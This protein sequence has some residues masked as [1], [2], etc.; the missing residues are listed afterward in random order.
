MLLK[1][2]AG[3][4]LTTALIICLSIILPAYAQTADKSYWQQEVNYKIRVRLDDKSH[5]ISGF[6]SFE[7]KNNSPETLTELYIHLWPNA[8]KDNSTALAKQQLENG[9]VAFHYYEDSQRGY[10]DSLDFEVDG[11]PVKMFY[12]PEYND[13]CKILL[14]KPLA[15]G[16]K[17][18]VTTPFRVNI[19]GSFSRLGHT[20]QAY[21]VSQWYPKP[22]VFDKNGWHPMPYLDQ[23]EF[24]SEFG[25]YE[26]S[27]T[28]PA[29]YVVGAT[30]NLQNEEEQRFLDSL[31]D[32]T[33]L[34]KDFP[35]DNS[36]PESSESWKTLTYKQSKIHDFAWFADKRYHV[37]KGSVTLPRSQ[38]KVDTWVMFTNDQAKYWKDAIP[39]VNDAITSY[40]AWL[41]EYPYEQATALSGGLGAGGGMEYPNVTVISEVNSARSLER[42]IV[43]EVGHNWFY[44]ILGSNERDHGWMDEGLNTYYETRYM[45]TKYPEMPLLGRDYRVA[46]WFKLDQYP[47]GYTNDLIYLLMARLNEDQPV[48]T[49][50]EDFSM[51]NYAGIMYAKTGLLLRYLEQYLGPKDFEIAMNTYYQRWKF[52]HP[53]PED[54]KLVFEQVT[55]KNLDWFF[56]DMINTS[57]KIDFKLKSV[58]SEDNDYQVRVAGRGLVAPVFISSL[59]KNGEVLETFRSEPFRGTAVFYFD[60]Q[61]VHEIRVDPYNAIPEINRQNNRMRVKGLFR[62]T[63]PIQLQ[64]LMSLQDRDRSQ[65]YFTPVLGYNYTDRWMPGIAL[66][67]HFFPL[68]P[69]EFELIPLYSFET[70]RLNGRGRVAYNWYPARGFQRITLSTHYNAF[71][72]DRLRTGVYD[73]ADNYIGTDDYLFSFRKIAVQAEFEWKRATERSK[74][75]QYINLRQVWVQRSVEQDRV[76][77][78]ETEESAVNRIDAQYQVLSYQLKNT[79]RLNP[80]FAKIEAER[81]SQNPNGFLKLSA[82]FTYNWTYGKGRKNASLRTFVGTGFTNLGVKTYNA[83]LYSLDGT[84]DYKYDQT[85][86]KRNDLMQQQFY[87]MEGGFKSRILLPN[88]DRMLTLNAKVP[89]PLPLPLGLYGDIAFFK[90][91]AV[92]YEQDYV[93]DFGLYVPFI[94]DLIEVYF[95]V[96]ISTKTSVSQPKYADRIRFVLNITEM[97]PF[98]LIRRINLR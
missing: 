6:E 5:T 13:V 41:G 43:H 95:P 48:E 97:D 27:I 73:P 32:A 24:Y 28:L 92:Y 10:I 49:F 16:K 11:E 94:R 46:H 80:Y 23:G 22:A 54:L 25:S 79:R 76:L 98:R 86:L 71:S 2:R 88:V 20:G 72:E 38:R 52:R 19:P 30:G 83:G 91:S 77:L 63:E 21:Q 61:D 84:S 40:S 37:L 66:Y 59:D 81:M 39:Y 9:S 75:R 56:G 7:Y 78:D 1:R 70:D 57:G 47:A 58:K 29:N 69:F 68:R 60:K 26:V 67:N 64:F 8:Y 89:L 12:H 74:T 4:I 44:G 85:Y 50:S 51:I 17:L 3:C 18:R 31:A 82:E 65:L 62:K 55:G 42:V 14:N 45:K 35:S 93:Y 53:Q 36:F 96:E 34:I 90:G 87:V 33:A 15:P